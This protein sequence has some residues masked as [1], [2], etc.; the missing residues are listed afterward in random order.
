MHT[1][2][3]VF[4]WIKNNYQKIILIIILAFC[5]TSL[6]SPNVFAEDS[7]DIV[8]TTFFGNLKDDGNGCGVYTILNAVLDIMTTGIGILGVI[9][10]IVVGIQYLTAGDNKTQTQKAK[11]RMVEIVIGLAAFAIL[12]SLLQWLLPGGKLNTDLKCETVSDETLAQM[13]EAEQ[14]AKQEAARASI[15]ADKSDKT[16]SSDSDDN[17]D[18]GGTSDNPVDASAPWSERIAQTAEL[19]AWPEGG[20]YKKYWHHNYQF[21]GNKF[22]KWSDLRTAKPNEAF[23][24]AI[25]TVWPRHSFKSVVGLGA[26]CGTFVNVVLAYSGHDPGKARNKKIRNLYASY[27]P[28]QKTWKEIKGGKL[29]RGDICFT[30]GGKFHTKVFLGNGKIAEAGHFSKNFGHITRG[31]CSSSFRVFRASN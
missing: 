22:K 23:M 28:K 11:R 30:K 25:D 13:R 26:D 7:S 17:N 12:Y 5:F 1:K 2:S 21:S 24:K 9:G 16:K 6:F 4:F 20:K 3:K 29:Q 8:E 15:E 18:P 19:L 14:K 27:F 31:G 10:I